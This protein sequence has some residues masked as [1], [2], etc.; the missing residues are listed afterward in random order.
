MS[1]TWFVFILQ[2]PQE[3]LTLCN[4]VLLYFCPKGLAI[5]GGTFLIFSLS[6]MYVFH[7]SLIAI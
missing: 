6:P 3:H 4:T 7:G 2:Q 5:P 1:F